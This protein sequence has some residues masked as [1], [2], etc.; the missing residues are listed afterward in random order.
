MAAGE[1]TDTRDERLLAEIRKLDPGELE[2]RKRLLAEL[3]A[4][5]RPVLRGLVASKLYPLGREAIEE[6]CQHAWLRLIGEIV[7]GKVWKV[8]FRVIVIATADFTCRDAWGE[9]RKRREREVFV[10]DVRAADARP[11]LDDEVMGA[12]IVD[13]FLG[14]LSDQDSEIVQL[15]WLQRQSSKEVGRRLSMTDNA[16]NQRK[17]RIKDKLRN[18]LDL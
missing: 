10:E 5:Y 7:Q 8:P 9:L 15:C 1:E 18:Y 11:D 2:L 14:T 6:W 13:G 16:I 3:L 4:P 17:H 12:M